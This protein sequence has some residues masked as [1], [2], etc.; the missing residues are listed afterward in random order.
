MELTVTNSPFGLTIKF[1]CK[2]RVECAASSECSCN[3]PKQWHETRQYSISKSPSSPVGNRLLEPVVRTRVSGA[4]EIKMTL[5]DH[6]VR[7]PPVPIPN[8]EVKPHSP[9]GTARASVWESRKLP[10]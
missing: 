7:V 2:Y 3:E 8:T 4:D 10:D 6:S 1:Y 9:D 5:G